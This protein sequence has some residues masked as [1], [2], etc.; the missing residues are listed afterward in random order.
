MPTLWRT[1]SGA[2]LLVGCLLLVA[3]AAAGE[4]VTIRYVNWVAGGTTQD[5]TLRNI[6]AFEAANPH[7]KIEYIP[8]EWAGETAYLEKFTVWAA[9]D[10]LP[11]VAHIP[12][13]ILPQLAEQGIV[14]PVN[15]ALERNARS[16]NLDDF[17]PISL[18]ASSWQG[19]IYGLPFDLSLWWVNYNADAFAEAGLA[20]PV[21]LYRNAEW[22]WQAM[23]EAARK[24]TRRTLDGRMERIGILT[25]P[26]DAGTYPWMWAYGGN[27]LDSAGTRARIGEPEA[28]TGISALHQLIYED[29]IL[30]FPSWTIPDGAAWPDVMTAGAFGMQ[31]WWNTLIDNYANMNVNWRYDQVPLPPGPVRPDTIPTHIHTVALMSGAEHVEEAVQFIAFL[32]GEGYRT[33]IQEQGFAPLR[34]SQYPAY[35]DAMNKRGIAGVQFFFDGIERTRLR[36]RHSLMLE[37]E[38]AMHSSLNSVWHNQAAVQITLTQLAERINVILSRQ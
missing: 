24:I 6:A 13:S 4:K 32:T 16:V 38:S 7:I 8:V 22:T 1:V 21:A 31:P 23:L 37:I 17:L 26:G 29:R 18:E 15:A 5:I 9:G 19:H 35:V 36:P 11:D 28:M 10:T 25:F 33:V 34:R 30:T 20:E 12:Y 2:L 3:A 14:Q 27:L